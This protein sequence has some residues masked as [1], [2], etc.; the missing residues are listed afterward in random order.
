M[1]IVYK[2]S[3]REFYVAA[4]KANFNTFKSFIEHPN[5]KPIPEWVWKNET[6]KRFLRE[7]L[8]DFGTTREDILLQPGGRKMKAMEGYRTY[9]ENQTMKPRFEGEPKIVLLDLAKDLELP[10]TPRS[11]KQE[12]CN[13]LYEYYSE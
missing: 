11:T 5:V 4:T 7:R 2:I 9:C 12:I 1:N 3:K 10:V 6:G 13:L 8:P